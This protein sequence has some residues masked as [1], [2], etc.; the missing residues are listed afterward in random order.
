M[1]K[2]GYKA[3]WVSTALAFGVACALSMTGC[4]AAGQNTEQATS[5]SETE[6]AT[7]ET[8][9]TSIAACDAA[10]YT[11][12]GEGV[13]LASLHNGRPLVINYWATWCPYCVDEL[14][15]FQAIAKEYAGRADFAFVDCTDEEEKAA[16]TEQWLA[17]NGLSDLTV[18]YDNDG[19]A[20]ETF[21]VYALPT[22]VIVSSDGKV[23]SVSAGG[24]DA[25]T[26]RNAIDSAL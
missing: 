2:Y 6:P 3:M 25:N 20:A 19:K 26:L 13:Q 8:T 22:T 15:D 9:V 1:K 12:S 16:T 21:D 10:V 17:D 24:M 5:S 23:V 11:A 7:M 14:P 4:G 18:Y